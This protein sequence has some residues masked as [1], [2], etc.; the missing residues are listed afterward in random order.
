ML[1]IKRFSLKL[2][3]KLKNVVESLAAAPSFIYVGDSAMYESCLK[4]D[5]KIL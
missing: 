2:Q 5:N 1:L 3:K 4:K